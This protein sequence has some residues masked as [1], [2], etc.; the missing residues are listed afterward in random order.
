[1]LAVAM[2][3]GLSGC[4]LLGSQKNADSQSDEDTPKT[5][6]STQTSFDNLRSKGYMIVTILDISDAEQ[7][8]V[9]P[10]DDVQPFYEIVLQKGSSTATCTVSMS[11]FVNLKD[12]TMQNTNYCTKRGTP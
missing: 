3:L 11:A 6:Q 12:V 10:N 9:W 2:L 5:P 1:M 7:K 4:S 8:A